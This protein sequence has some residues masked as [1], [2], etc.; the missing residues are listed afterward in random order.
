MSES[1]DNKKSFHDGN[2]FN[3]NNQV[4]DNTGILKKIGFKIFKF[5]IINVGR[6]TH[7]AA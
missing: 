4:A 7:L 2:L 3:A 1:S 5:W 6:P